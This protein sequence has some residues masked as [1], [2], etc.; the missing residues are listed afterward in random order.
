MAD[1]G[2]HP[3]DL[4]EL[5]EKLTGR[6]LLVTRVRLPVAC[7]AAP[8][9]SGNRGWAHLGNL[10]RLCCQLCA[11]LTCCA[12]LLALSLSLSSFTRRV[13]T[14]LGSSV[15]VNNLHQRVSAKREDFGSSDNAGV[16][17]DDF[18]CGDSSKAEAFVEEPL[19]DNKLHDFGLVRGGVREAGFALFVL[20]LGVFNSLQPLQW[21][22][23]D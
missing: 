8:G 2:C 22:G 12:T 15:V 18:A 20:Q 3:R 23:S 11:R 5:L 16:G 13:L 6:G 1:R 9:S 10:L 17:E 4:L 19:V 21:P 7:G 14:L